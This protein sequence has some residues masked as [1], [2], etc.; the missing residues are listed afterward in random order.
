MPGFLVLQRTSYFF[1][2]H[3]FFLHTFS[4]F[5]F[6]LYSFFCA[7]H[8]SHFSFLLLSFIIVMIFKQILHPAG[9]FFFYIFYFS[10]SCVFFLVFDA[11]AN[12]TNQSKACHFHLH[13]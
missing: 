12:R 3:I 9:Y 6:F 5:E 8:L 7:F 10:D 4:L 13:K 1:F 11:K 2:L